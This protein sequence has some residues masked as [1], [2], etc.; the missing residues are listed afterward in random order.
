MVK[1]K[2]N[3]RVV[4]LHPKEWSS[5]LYKVPGIEVKHTEIGGPI[6]RRMNGAVSY[7]GI[8][9]VLTEEGFENLRELVTSFQPH[10]LLFGIHIGFTAFHL[11]KLKARCRFIKFVMHYTD[12]RPSVSK[13]IKAHK[14]MID[15]LLITNQDKADYDLYRK[16]QIVR[17]DTFFDGVSPIEYYPKPTKIKYDVFFGGNNF[18]GL[19]RILENRRMNHPAPWIRKFTGAKF[20]EDFILEVNDCFNLV[21]RGENGWDDFKE[22]LNLQPMTF[23]PDYLSSLREAKINLNTINVKRY[24][25]LTRRFFRTMASGRLFLTEYCDGLESHF[26]NHEHLVWFNGIEEGLD[27]IKYYL[28]HDGERERIASK[29]R[30]EILLKHTFETRLQQFEKLARKYL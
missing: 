14:D 21:I 17:V 10:I 5:G 6:P 18:W 2:G 8:G 25:L 13:F 23:H 1:V 19:N 9:Q 7:D 20:R 26:K 4:A 15:V 3:I 22:I 24:G 27:L 11:K 12:Q 16:S 30:K 28:D 29:G